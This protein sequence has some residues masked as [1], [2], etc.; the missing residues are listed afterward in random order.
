MG[1]VTLH[2]RKS[3]DR[4][5]HAVPLL[6]RVQRRKERG[7]AVAK[8]R[9]S[10]RGITWGTGRNACAT[11]KQDYFWFLGESFLM[12]APFFITK[13]ILRRASVS[14]SGLAGMA[15]MSAKRPEAMAP[16]SF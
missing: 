11:E 9:E 15:I 6:K 10:C 8:H 5:R 13:F 4:A 2:A 16:R 14:S 3:V 12:T 7:R 1:G